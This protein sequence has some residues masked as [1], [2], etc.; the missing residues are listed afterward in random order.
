MKKILQ[1]GQFC[2]LVCEYLSDRSRVYNVAIYSDANA[3]QLPEILCKDEAA[4][5]K[6]FNSIEENAIGIC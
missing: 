1:K 4:A 2:S 3:T 5:Q 6:V